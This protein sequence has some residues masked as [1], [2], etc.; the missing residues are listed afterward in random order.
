MKAGWIVPVGVWRR[1]VLLPVL[2]A[3]R[4]SGAGEVAQSPTDLNAVHRGTAEIDRAI[5]GRSR[6]A[7]DV[8]A[9]FAEV[10]PLFDVHRRATFAD[11]P[12]LQSAAE[13]HGLV[14][15]GGPMLGALA[16]DGARVWVRTLRPAQVEVRV[17]VDG[18]ERRFGPVASTRE[19]DFAAVVAV[20][21]LPAGVRHPYRVLVD[22]RAVPLPPD[23]AIATPTSPDAGGTLTLAFGADFHKSGLGDRALLDRIGRRGA[24]ALVLLGDLAV[25]DRDGDV[26]L[27]RADYLLRDLQPGWRNLVASIPVYAV[28]D[29]HDYF[30]N[31]RSGIPPGFTDADRAAV[32]KVWAQNWNNPACG[33]A[34]REEGIYFR[35]RIGPCDLIMLDTRSLRTT[36]GAP[37]AF[38]GSAQMQWLERELAACAGPFVLLTSGTMWS[39]NVSAGKD[40]WGVWD[41]AA[42]EHI[43]SLIEAR[44]LPVVLLSGDRHGAR[45]IRIPR[46]SGHVFWEFELGSLGAHPGPPAYGMPKENQPFA[47]VGEAL[48]GECSIDTRPADPTA[49]FRVIDAAGT[50]RWSV[51]LSRSAVTPGGTRAD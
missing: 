22:G 47:A 16:P 29:D 50:E 15:T 35:T 23:A 12:A 25:D 51:T 34:A 17:E 3:L 28:W 40:S 7:D 45:V 2:L 38:L 14:L 11:L 6:P 1:A 42:R 27:H 33:D 26:G 20:T 39:D 44:R 32:R 10:R 13:R 49:T 41:P 21:G 18:V 30:N 9:F 31:D 8:Q 36:R 4:V 19:S 46:P 24:S 5:L 48:F 43:F 37:D